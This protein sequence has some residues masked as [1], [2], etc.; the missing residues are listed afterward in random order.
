VKSKSDSGR[1]PQ[2]PALRPKI[3]RLAPTLDCLRLV[4]SM[5]P[6]SFQAPATSQSNPP[7]HIPIADMTRA[8]ILVAG[9]TK[10]RETWG[11]EADCDADWEM[12]FQALSC[13]SS[14]V[15]VAFV[16]SLLMNRFW[17]F[18]IPEQWW[19][20]LNTVRHRYAHRRQK[21]SPKTS[22]LVLADKS[23]PGRTSSLRHHVRPNGRSLRGES[24][25]CS[26]DS[27]IK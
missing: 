12:A 9:T 7:S 17:W 22:G 16:G 15:L 1:R 10:R 13:A 14:M 19:L 24:Q 25:S 8:H 11:N 6:S 26:A 20:G 5:Q 27:P 4:H 2:E 3:G 23:S 18:R 21:Q